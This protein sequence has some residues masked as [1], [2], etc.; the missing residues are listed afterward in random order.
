MCTC[1]CVCARARMHVSVC[2]GIEVKETPVIVGPHAAFLEH[3][4][5]DGKKGNVL[6]VRVV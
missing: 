3:V 1:V 6:D 5:R 4:G 2:T